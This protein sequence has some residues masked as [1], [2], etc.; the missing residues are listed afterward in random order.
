MRMTRTDDQQVGKVH[1]EVDYEER[2]M[3][4]Y[5]GKSGCLHLTRQ[6]KAEWT[7]EGDNMRNECCNKVRLEQE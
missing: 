7:S 6:K 2:V 4:S 3:Y 5:N 1:Q